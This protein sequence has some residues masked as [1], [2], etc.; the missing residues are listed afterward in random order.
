[1]LTQIPSLIP[2]TPLR[3]E[4]EA[5]PPWELAGEA[6]GIIERVFIGGQHVKESYLP[7][8]Q[9]DGVVKANIQC[10]IL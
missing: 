1:M 3:W 10:E 2:S 9:V 6:R 5:D 8:N 4:A 7:W